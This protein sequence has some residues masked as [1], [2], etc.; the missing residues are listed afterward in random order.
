M[1]GGAKEN[2]REAPSKD[3]PFIERSLL[4]P[5]DGKWPVEARLGY[6]HAEGPLSGRRPVIKLGKP[7]APLKASYDR[8]GP[9][10]LRHSQDSLVP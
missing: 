3:L 8:L 6:P 7:P 10:E 9:G 1:L 5:E 4:C 2:E